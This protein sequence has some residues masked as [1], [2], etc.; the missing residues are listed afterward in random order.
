MGMLKNKR[1]AG[2]RLSRL[3]AI[4]MTLGECTCTHD[5]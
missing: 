5:G 3:F 2:A 1:Y 4:N